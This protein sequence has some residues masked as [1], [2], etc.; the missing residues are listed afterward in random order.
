MKYPELQLLNCE[1]VHLVD[2]VKVINTKVSE[3]C[4]IMS[5]IQEWVELESVLAAQEMQ[6]KSQEFPSATQLASSES[7]G[8]SQGHLSKVLTPGKLPKLKKLNRS[9]IHW[10]QS[11]G[12]VLLQ[13]AT[14]E[15][16]RTDNDRYPFSVRLVFDWCSQW[17]YMTMNLKDKLG[18]PVTGRESLL[19]KTFG[20]SDVRLQTCDIVQEGIKTICDAIE[21]IQ[22]CVVPVICGP[23]T[24]QPK[25]PA[26]SSYEQLHDLSSANR[27]GGGD[28]PISIL[29]GA[30]YYE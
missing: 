24:Q 25:E 27:C 8:T 19:I 5:A 26:Q 12:S 30:D 14:T 29:I 15:V 7:A 23:L 20:E 18:L 22:A 10:Y 4:E 11:R 9:L 3:S 21:Y 17:S 13:T 1:I 28:L 6:A 16:V 2:D